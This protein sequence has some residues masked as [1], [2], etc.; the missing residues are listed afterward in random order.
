MAFDHGKSHT[1][2]QK[3]T[4]HCIGLSFDALEDIKVIYKLELPCHCCLLP[5]FHV[6]CL[7]PVTPGLLAE[8]VPP[9]TPPTHLDIKG[10]PAYIV[11]EILNSQHKDVKLQDLIEWE[12]YSPEEGCWIPAHKVLYLLFC[13]VPYPT[14]AKIPVL[15]L[16]VGP[17]KSLLPE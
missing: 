5:S 14:H 3:L 12:G 16:E 4:H 9:S 6:A 15:M 13:R 7:K 11:K 10:Q 2:L 8:G 1:R 17:E